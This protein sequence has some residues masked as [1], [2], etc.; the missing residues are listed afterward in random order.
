MPW[1]QC[2]GRCPGARVSLGTPPHNVWVPLAVPTAAATSR[3]FTLPRHTRHCP[4]SL[5]ALCHLPQG[6]ICFSIYSRGSQTPSHP[7][8]RKTSAHTIG[9]LEKNTEAP[10]F[11]MRL[12][13]VSMD[14]RSVILPTTRMNHVPV[15]C[16]ERRS[17][18]LYTRCSLFRT[19]PI[20]LQHTGS[21]QNVL[22]GR[23]EAFSQPALHWGRG[24][25]RR[26]LTVPREWQ[27]CLSLLLQHS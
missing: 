7:L 21:C 1:L 6:P 4:I 12:S 20:P 24:R 5:A 2:L 16:P 17:W 14:S 3:C 10:L 15:N 8:S 25:D 19:R 22:K 26:G 27:T 23:R 13:I 9:H 18:A 11:S